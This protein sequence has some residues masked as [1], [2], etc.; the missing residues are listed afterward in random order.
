MSKY[1]QNHLRYFIRY[2]TM[3]TFL[4]YVPPVTPPD[5]CILD[6]PN[7]LRHC[8]ANGGYAETLF[9]LSAEECR[10][11]C[12]NQ[13]QCALAHHHPGNQI[14][15]TDSRTNC[16]LWSSDALPCNWGDAALLGN[17]PGATMITCNKGKYKK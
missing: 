8:D 17:H 12:E 9:N 10:E 14:W 16:W 2:L 15:S 4:D 13:S 5:E 6:N 3:S 7:F 1:F 11:I